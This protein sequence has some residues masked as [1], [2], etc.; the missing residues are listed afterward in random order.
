M[1]RFYK[2]AHTFYAGIDLHARTLYLCITDAEGNKRL[3]RELKCQVDELELALAP[4][5][6][7][8]VVACE[9]TFCWYWLAD[10]MHHAE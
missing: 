10:A 4:F 2:N 3:H 9:T 8:L 1:M 7:G 6:E 5:R